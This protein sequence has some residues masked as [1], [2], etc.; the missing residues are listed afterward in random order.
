[1]LRV[2]GM[3]DASDQTFL[4]ISTGQELVHMT[5]IVCVATQLQIGRVLEDL[6]SLGG[7]EGRVGLVQRL[8]GLAPLH[9]HLLHLFT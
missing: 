4:S 1:M 2:V 9:A 6:L 7:H 3:R 8:Q 5:G